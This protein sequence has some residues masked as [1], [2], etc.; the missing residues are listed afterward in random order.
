MASRPPMFSPTGSKAQAR[1]VMNREALDTMDL[2]VADALANVSRAILQA[3]QRRVPVDTGD[4]RDSG[5]WAVFGGAKK[6]SGTAAKPKALRTAKG[7]ITAVV[8]FGSPLAHLIERGTALR[9]TEKPSRATGRGPA[10]PFLLPATQEVSSGELGRE[11][12][13][14]MARRGLSRPSAP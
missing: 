4:L 2:A 5:D 14:A 9:A 10:I 13:T 11:V 12:E 8:G 7:V 3:A 6:L 1:V